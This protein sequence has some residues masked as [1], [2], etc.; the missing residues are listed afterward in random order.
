MDEFKAKI[1]KAIKA[2]FL[3]IFFNVFLIFI[4]RINDRLC[5]TYYDHKIN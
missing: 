4:P 3:K 1:V 5:K 2:L